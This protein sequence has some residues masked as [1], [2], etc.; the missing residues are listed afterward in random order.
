MSK[1]DLNIPCLDLDVDLIFSLGRDLIFQ[2]SDPD[3]DSVS[4]STRIQDGKPRL[5][6]FLKIIPN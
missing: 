3:L 2:S 4:N 5:F 6:E 1:L